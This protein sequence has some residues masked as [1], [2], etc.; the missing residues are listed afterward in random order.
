MT[1]AVNALRHSRNAEHRGRLVPPLDQSGVCAGLIFGVDALSVAASFLLSP[2]FGLRDLAQAPEGT[3]REQGPVQ[4]IQDPVR[5]SCFWLSIASRDSSEP[6]PLG[7]LIVGS[8][9][10]RGGS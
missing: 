7:A 10:C 4:R 3:S 9:T 2:A 6:V 1:R 8:H 5:L